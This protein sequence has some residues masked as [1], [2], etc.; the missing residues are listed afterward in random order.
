[1]NGLD[2]QCCLADS[3]KTALRIFIFSTVLCADNSFYVKLIAIYAFNLF[4][5]IISVWASVNNN[6]LCMRLHL[7]ECV[8]QPKN[9][10][11]CWL[12]RLCLTSFSLKMSSP[13]KNFLRTEFRHPYFNGR[14]SLYFLWQLSSQWTLNHT[15][16][17]TQRLGDVWMKGCVIFMIFFRYKKRE[18]WFFPSCP[19]AIWNFHSFAI[20][21]DDTWKWQGRRNRRNTHKYF[22]LPPSLR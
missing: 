21:N 18:T 22:E 11:N 14:S 16:K 1:M 15:W 17:C 2:W 12:R 6:C 10:E 8:V 13:E 7:P 5:Y 20:L 19:I 3:S 9:I 4:G